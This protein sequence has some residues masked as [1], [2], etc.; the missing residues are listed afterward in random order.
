LRYAQQ[1]ICKR[2]KSQKAIR[3]SFLN[4]QYLL[5]IKESSLR[6]NE[7][8]THRELFKPKNDHEKK[9]LVE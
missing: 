2:V 6:N 3:E 5:N 8:L 1:D 4:D 9:Y 7:R